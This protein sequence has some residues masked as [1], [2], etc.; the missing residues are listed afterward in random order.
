[1][2]FGERLQLRLNDY[3]EQDTSLFPASTAMNLDPANEDPARIYSVMIRAI[4]PRPIAWVS[5]ISPRGKT[6]LAPFSYFNGICSQPAAL[7]FSPVNKPDGS[8]KDTVRNIEA[9]GEFVVN[10]VP[11][12]LA[13]VMAKT[14]GEFAYEESEFE[15]V[16]VTAEPGERVSPPRVAESPVQFE[17]QLIQIVPV[18]TGPL[19][20]NV[21]I[22]KILLMHIRDDV[23]DA[24]GKIDPLRVDSIGRMGGRGYCR[25]RE[26]FTI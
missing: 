18:G 24:E 11:Y 5:T 12:A 22:G 15:A 16:G 4:T 17:C 26:Q 21:V 25:T 1:L 10:V 2:P 8:K 9:N 14:A 13:E 19:A 20:A 23:L 6:N 7:M 3:H